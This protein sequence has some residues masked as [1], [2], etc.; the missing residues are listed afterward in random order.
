MIQIAA[1]SVA[2]ATPSAPGQ[3]PTRSANS[4]ETGKFA[5][6]LARDADHAERAR[7]APQHAAAP[8][9]GGK[10]AAAAPTDAA[11]AEPNPAAPRP[12]LAAALPAGG[13]I[14]PDGAAGLVDPSAQPAAID[15]AATAP[16]LPAAQTIPGLLAAV[17][18]IKVTTGEPA[19]AA[20]VPAK[21]KARTDAAG[22]AGDQPGADADSA[23][24]AAPAPTALALLTN[25]LLPAAATAAPAS[26][27]T[28]T[29]GAAPA[30]PAL[31]Q[32]APAVAQSAANAAAAGPDP[33]ASQ[34]GTTTAALP[35]AIAAQM[36]GVP[37]PAASNATQ[38]ATQP[39]PA[40]DAALALKVDP[41]AAQA[42]AAPAFSLEPAAARPMAA[43]KLRPVVASDSQPG[44]PAAPGLDL[45]SPLAGQVA[46]APAAANPAMPATSPAGL[47]LANRPHDFTGL[48]DRLI[49]ARDAAQTGL[50]QTVHMSLNHADFG[51]I[52]L[53]FQQDRGGLAVSVASADPDFARAVQAAIPAP[54]AATA[55]TA[56][57]DS[58]QGSGQ[59]AALA[60]SFARADGSGAGES[61]Q[62][63][64]R[65]QAFAGDSRGPA[66]NRSLP[67]D[68]DAA[69]PRGIFA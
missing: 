25:P 48:V 59:Q 54:G 52:S 28:A 39:Q 43:V 68:E 66:A 11:E 5:Q 1:P 57:R 13:K 26:T 17:R 30:G 18:A 19:E 24:G 7:P 6:V 62:R 36:A 47:P 16:A 37:L 31:P 67:R 56:S 60:Q 2:S 65:G 23:P 38:T 22:E 61:G 34:P 32:T 20:P 49:A 55:D 14:L 51:P 8:P 63:Q 69:R 40:A 42:A 21:G 53:N 50:P 9:A 27:T 41:A 10:A 58:R 46:G 35:A 29:T 45:T 44:T 15:P 3:S 33:V 4:P 12:T 64:A